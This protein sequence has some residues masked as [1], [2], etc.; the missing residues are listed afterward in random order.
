MP[1]EDKLPHYLKQNLLA[2]SLHPQTYQNNPN[3]TNFVKRSGLPFEPHERFDKAA[4]Q[5]R[6]QLYRQIC[7]QI[8]NPDRLK[9]I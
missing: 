8:W 7:E 1:Y 5:Q 9:E 4:L 3:F 6:K 2:A